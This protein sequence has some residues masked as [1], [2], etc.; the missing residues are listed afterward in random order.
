MRSLRPQTSISSDSHEDETPATCHAAA[1]QLCSRRRRPVGRRLT[2][3]RPEL[4]PWSRRSRGLERQ[5]CHLAVAKPSAAFD[6]Q[7]VSNPIG[8][9]IT[10]QRLYAPG[11]GRAF[12]FI[13]IDV[14]KLRNGAQDVHV[15]ED[16]L[17]RSRTVS[18]VFPKDYVHETK[19]PF[20]FQPQDQPILRDLNIDKSQSQFLLSSDSLYTLPQPRD[21]NIF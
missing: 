2:V 1:A 11:D 10:A 4:P 20:P 15:V 14:A 6:L 18:R 17:S 3:C 9:A 16:N 12:E 13:V 19:L 8:F 5:L 21:S 7:R